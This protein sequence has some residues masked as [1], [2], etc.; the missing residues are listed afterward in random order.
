MAIDFSILFDC[1]GLRNEVEVYY[2]CGFNQKLKG[3]SQVQQ[4]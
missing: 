2:P 1:C 3:N 4:F